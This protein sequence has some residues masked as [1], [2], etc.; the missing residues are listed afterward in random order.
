MTFDIDLS[1]IQFKGYLEKEGLSVR[2]WK[3]RYFVISQ[4]SLAY[5]KDQDLKEK[6]G[7]IPLIDCT[8]AL[9]GALDAAPGFYFSLHFPPSTGAKRGTYNFRAQT[10]ENREE[11]IREIRKANKTTIFEKPLPVAL[12]VN[13]H[14]HEIF[15]PIPYFIVRAVEYLN[16]EALDIEGIYRHNGSIAQ[17]EALQNQINNNTDITFSAPHDTTGIIKLYLRTLPEPLLLK[18]NYKAMKKICFTSQIDLEL[19]AE[20]SKPIIRS[21][22]ISHY[23]LV[24]FLFKHLSELLQHENKTKMSAKAISVCIGPSLIVSDENDDDNALAESTVQQNSCQLLLHYLD[25]IFTSNPLMVYASNGTGDVYKLNVD[26]E[27]T[28]PY[29]IP[30]T[31]GT[32]IQSVAEDKD[33]WMIC[34]L[35]DKWG[36]FHKTQVVEVDSPKEIIKG[37]CTQTGKWQIPPV[38]Q[39]KINEKCPEANQLYEL[40]STKL[41]QLREEALKYV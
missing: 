30:A 23:L 14:N 35:N 12:T 25:D 40:L 5:F 16:R 6:L 4:N 11:W 32:I 7:T 22:P 38:L 41:Q 28:Y 34:V 10:A 3:S 29:T 27:G 24:H 1:K 19:Q 37:L 17:I 9:E 36:V 33:G 15:L 13:P 8:I 20:A 26:I 2:S 21:L 39:R 31:K 18:K